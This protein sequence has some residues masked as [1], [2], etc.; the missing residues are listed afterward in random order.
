MDPEG[1]V[2]ATET[3]TEFSACN[4][5]VSETRRTPSVFGPDPRV[6]SGGT[7]RD[8]GPE[9]GVGGRVG[10]KSRGWGRRCP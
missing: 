3:T 4:F 9:V 10:S 5:R 2:V 8:K 6:G 7:D 1:L